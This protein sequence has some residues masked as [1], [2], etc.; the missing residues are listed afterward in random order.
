MSSPSVF[1][2]T[3]IM[4]KPLVPA[5]LSVRHSVT[6]TG[7]YFGFVIQA[8]LPS[9]IQLSP[10]LTALVRTPPARSD[11]A[12][13]SVSA[14]EPSV[15]PLVRRGRYLSLS[16]SLPHFVIGKQ[17]RPLCAA[18]DS[19]VDPQARPTSSRA[20]AALIVSR[21]APPYSSGTCSPVSPR[22]GILRIASMR[23]SPV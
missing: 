20:I 2:S 8:L 4:L 5:A 16:A 23:S 3:R 9:M 21:F 17:H 12:E 6:I 1:G 11:P 19:P 15:S 13:G 10:S 22:L 18:S 14:S 7:A